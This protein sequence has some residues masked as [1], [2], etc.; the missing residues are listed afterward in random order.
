MRRSMF[1]TRA[2]RHVELS[3]LQIAFLIVFLNHPDRGL[4]V[5]LDDDTE[6]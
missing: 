1:V 4:I 5:Q 2:P 6:M 3:S